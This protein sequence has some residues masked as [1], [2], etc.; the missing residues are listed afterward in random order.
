MLPRLNTSN[1]KTRDQALN[2]ILK[3]MTNSL[4]IPLA[5]KLEESG[6]SCCR[7]ECFDL[8]CK[9]GN[10][11]KFLCYDGYIKHTNDCELI[12][13]SC[14][15][16]FKWNNINP[17]EQTYDHFDSISETFTSI[18]DNTWYDDFKFFFEQQQ[19]NH[20]IYEYNEKDETDVA[21][22]NYAFYFS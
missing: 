20:N 12:R 13:C 7:S 14:D 1:A 3:Q 18:N 11:Y 9:V 2:I 22:K 10:E 15:A 21:K 16:P 4:Y 8:I 5:Y 19:E 6:C 17:T